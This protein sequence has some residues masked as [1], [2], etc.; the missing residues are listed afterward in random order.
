MSFDLSNYEDVNSRIK[1]FRLEFPCGR[2]VAYIED[3]DITKGY[4]LMRAE[5]YRDEAD[6]NPA[7]IDYAFEIRTD[8]GVNQLNWVENCTTSVYG[9]VIG[10]LT[11]SEVNRATVQDMQRVTEVAEI[12]ADDNKWDEWVGV[13][14]AAEAIAEIEDQLGG[15]LQDAPPSCK[16]GTMVELKGVSNKTGKEYFGYKCTAVTKQQQCE[17]I[18]YHFSL[19]EK[20]WL[21]N[22]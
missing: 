12:K 13:P 2:L 19:T 10:L 21:P 14:K 4:I 5:A 6:T 16:H 20:V 9:R 22:G 17:T 7:A 3:I 8:R 18:W 11:P 15:R 1:R